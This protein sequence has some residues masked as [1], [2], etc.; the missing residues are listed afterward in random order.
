MTVKTKRME[1]AVD[2]GTLA[3][4]LADF[5]VERGVPFRQGHQVVGAIVRAAQQ[6]GQRRTDLSLADLR[7]H[8]EAFDE[9]SLA[10]LTPRASLARRNLSGGTG[11]EAVATQ[12][13]QARA[14]LAAAGSATASAAGSV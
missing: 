5:L 1:A 10:R 2:D 11:P 3:T 8:H 14:I 4:E 9:E 6:T 7:Q 12:I 13:E